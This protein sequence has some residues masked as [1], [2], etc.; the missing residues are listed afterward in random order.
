MISLFNEEGPVMMLCYIPQRQA[1]RAVF[2]LQQCFRPPSVS[3]PFSSMPS[4]KCSCV[5]K[6][7]VRFVEAPDSRTLLF[8]TNEAVRRRVCAGAGLQQ[9]IHSI[10]R[11]VMIFFLGNPR[12][13]STSTSTSLCY[14]TSTAMFDHTPPWTDLQR[15]STPRARRVP[16]PKRV[17]LE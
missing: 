16:V 10:C 5:C 8:D 9:Q 2:S 7:V 17:F 11:L 1:L 6:L 13:T 15:S 3:P 14:D 4:S 12:R